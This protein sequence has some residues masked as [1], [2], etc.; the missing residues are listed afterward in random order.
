MIPISP[1]MLFTEWLHT[2]GREINHLLTYLRT[3]S[4]T[5]SSVMRGTISRS[6]RRH[7]VRATCSAALTCPPPCQWR[8]M[9]NPTLK[10]FLHILT[11]GKKKIA[12]LWLDFFFSVPFFVT[13]ETANN[14]SM[15]II[16]LKTVKQLLVL[17]LRYS[18]IVNT[19]HTLFWL[20]DGNHTQVLLILHD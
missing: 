3:W 20:N 18:C 14:N 4:S 16:T 7:T 12:I 6:A 5:N 1:K 10:Y 15:Y 17:K 8:S 11:S 9:L 13:M 2:G 19:I